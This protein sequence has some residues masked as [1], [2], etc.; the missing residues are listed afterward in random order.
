MSLRFLWIPGPAGDM[1]AILH[2]P[3]SGV[4]VRGCVVMFN[5]G[6]VGRAGPHRLYTLAAEAWVALGFK[7]MRVDL[8]GVGEHPSDNDQ[9]HFDGHRVDEAAAVIDYV[10]ST[11]KAPAFY[12]QGLCAGARVALR[13]AAQRP[14]V[15]GILA[16]GCPVI[17]SS[18]TALKSPLELQATA[19]AAT[20]QL[21]R[22]AARDALR[23][24]KFLDP[25]WLW[26]RLTGLRRE[27]GRV[28]GAA[29]AT[30]E[31]RQHVRN[32]FLDDLDMLVDGGRPILFV[33]GQRDTL[34]LGEFRERYPQITEQDALAR[35]ACL[36]L[37][38]ASHTFNSLE[39]IHEA[40]QRSGE[41]LAAHAGPAPSA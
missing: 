5:S 12:V 9:R 11:L 19:D 30:V 27:F 36:V 29:K 20:V 6:Q 8:A 26:R 33:Y 15:R 28:A 17:S 13:A 41:W 3:P 2:R 32:P 37:P 39:T 1:P 24:G 35:Q 25:A 7:V 31:R 23:T 21:T 10:T 38:Y 34:P 18:P 14:V 16:W 22:M 40:I 4:E